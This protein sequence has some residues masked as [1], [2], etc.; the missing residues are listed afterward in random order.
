MMKNEKN[1]SVCNIYAS[2]GKAVEIKLCRYEE[3]IWPWNVQRSVNPFWKFFMPLETGG[4]IFHNGKSIL[5]E[6]GKM[7]IIPRFTEHGT[8]SDSPFSLFFIHFDLAENILP[9]DNIWILDADSHI[10]ELADK[11]IRHEKKLEHMQIVTFIASAVVSLALLQL[12]EKL[13]L[14]QGSRDERILDT[15]RYIEDNP[16][17]NFDNAELA[18][19]IGLNRNSFIR[20]FRNELDESPQNFIKRKK[21]EESCRM[22]FAT[23]M[24][25]DEI[26]ESLGFANRFHFSR[27]FKKVMNDPPAL[28][29]R[30]ATMGD[31]F[32][33][34]KYYGKY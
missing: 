4:R 17:K 15:V 8:V 5:L 26:A 30:Q 10:R 31:I 21:I 16:R 33:Y 28:F 18:A 3:N 32:N 9:S 6:P 13:F 29:R 7:Y 2:V 1:I 22:L 25:I 34:N 23:D 20:L 14:L 24:S 12:P 11:F 19:R 27:I